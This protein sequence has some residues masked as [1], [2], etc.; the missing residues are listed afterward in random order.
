MTTTDGVYP[1]LGPFSSPS[2]A[3]QSLS[4]LTH[5]LHQLSSLTPFAFPAIIPGHGSAYTAAATS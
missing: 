5:A 2:I 4:P 1:T 3:D